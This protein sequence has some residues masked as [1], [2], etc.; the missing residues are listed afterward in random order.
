M[1]LNDETINEITNYIQKLC[2]DSYSEGCGDVELHYNEAV[3]QQG[4]IEGWNA[5]RKV[6]REYSSEVLK[7]VF[8]E[9]Y[10]TFIMNCSPLDA[11]TKINEYEN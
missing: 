6:Y 10:L 4:I 3:Y 2:D 11:M 5:A 8:G 9:D 1:R 7:E